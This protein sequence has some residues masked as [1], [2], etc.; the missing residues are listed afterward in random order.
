M[1]DAKRYLLAFCPLYVDSKAKLDSLVR[2]DLGGELL[3]F[4]EMF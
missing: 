1:I 3:D 4:W 2:L